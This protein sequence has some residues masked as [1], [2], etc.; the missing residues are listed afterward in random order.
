[1]ES[2]TQ[3]AIC[4]YLQIK[5]HFFW[6]N[7]NTPIFDP[8]SRKYRAM[9]LYAKRGIPDIIVIKDGKFIGIEVKASK[10][11]QSDY[12]KKFQDECERAGGIYFIAKSIDD[13]IK[14]GL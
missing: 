11:I 2:E 13:V 5:R 3:K 8:S 6:R 10:G 14:Q 12:Q 1:M 4:D 9:P 7:N